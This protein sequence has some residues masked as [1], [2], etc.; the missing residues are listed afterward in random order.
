MSSGLVFEEFLALSTGRLL[1]RLA[2]G[3]GTQWFRTKDGSSSRESAQVKLSG[4]LHA[5][6]DAG[7]RHIDEAEM[8]GT[9][10]LTGEALEAW[11]TKHPHVKREDLFITS[12][13]WRGLPNVR[14]TVETTLRN[15]RTPYVDL[16]LVHAPFIK[17][18]DIDADLR[19][20]WKEL[21]ALKEEGLIKDIG[22][23]NFHV[24]HLKELLSFCKHAP[25][26]N[27]IE[28]HPHL[29]QPDLMAFCQE[30]N[31]VVSSYAPLAS[32]G[33]RHEPTLALV[34][35]IAAKHNLTPGQVLLQ[36]NLAQGTAVITT[37]SKLDHIK[38]SAGVLSG[39]TITQ[40]DVDAI[41]KT[42]GEHRHR[43]FWQ[44]SF[45]ALNL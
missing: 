45:A 2:F 26:V 22:V 43:I 1:P 5:A 44:E 17:Q 41:T 6:L 27:Q 19:T 20:A 7:F 15:L 13:I 23:S 28:C 8:Y 9:E 39:A 10:E 25:V 11:M 12:K 38:E 42:A 29:L 34:Q 31:I 30:Q 40:E 32:F 35:E 14:K 3:T 24:V 18:N 4:A 21:E 16:Y 37:S 33:Q 36:W